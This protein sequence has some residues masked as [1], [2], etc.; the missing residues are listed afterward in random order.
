MCQIILNYLTFY[1]EKQ[2]P[3]NKFIRKEI[4]KISTLISGFR[5]DLN[6]FFIQIELLSFEYESDL[7]NMICWD[8]HWGKMLAGIQKIR[9]EVADAKFEKVTTVL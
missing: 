3:S 9:K 8:E 1:Q 6:T 2:Q 7:D 4:P 5:A